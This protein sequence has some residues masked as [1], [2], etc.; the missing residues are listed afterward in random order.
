MLGYSQATFLYTALLKA[1][2]AA[3]VLIAWYLCWY[4]RFESQWLPMEKGLPEFS[5]YSRASLPLVVGVSLL[6]HVV[7]AYRSDRIQFGFRA[8]KKILEGSSLGVLVFVAACY[9]LNEGDFSRLFLA[10]Y[11][12]VL[13]GSLIAER[14]VLHFGW[15][16][17][18][19]T[20]VRKIR[21]LRIGGGELLQMYVDKIQKHTPYPVEWVGHIPLGEEDTLATV[22]AEKKPEQ[23]VVAFPESA[24][25]R[26]A[27]I[28]EFLSEEL[29]EVKV[30][31]DFGK[32]STFTYQ[33]KHE[34]GIPLLAFN[35]APTSASDR[36]LKRILDI[37]GSAAVLVVF[38]P[39]Y[40]ALALLVRATGPGPIFFSQTRVGADGRRF[41]LY[42]FRTMR[43]D[44]EVQSGPI[45]AVENDPRTTS[46]GK[47]LRR[48]SLDEIPQFWNVLKGEMSLVGPRPER[49]EFVSRFKK[50]IPKYM[51][52]HKM[53]S[54]I[55]GWAQINGWRGNTSLNERIKHDLYYIGHW[56]HFLDMKILCLTVIKGFVNRHA[57]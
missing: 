51:L 3:T 16:Q 6:L 18:V 57:Y 19:K 43:T 45:W 26:Y 47:W 41:V 8:V 54:G 42:K 35:H 15:R 11:L 40:F 32:Y 20:G 28:L 25:N 34:A 33:A 24:S 9:F 22:L 1:A 27:P 52:R 44:A 48:S 39:L 5:Y 13:S 56:S 29:V 2:D 14:A 4:F 12:A 36:A 46:I 55:T 50:E 23:V 37:L 21:I 7:G 38:S 53:K 49:P 10:L 17:L 31:P 30:L